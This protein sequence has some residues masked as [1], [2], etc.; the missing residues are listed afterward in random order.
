MSFAALAAISLIGGCNRPVSDPA[1]L[2]AI[3]A[4]AQVLMRKHPV[5]SGSVYRVPQRDWPPVL[6]GLHPEMITVYGWGVDIR[7]KAYF[8]GGW[9]YDVPRNKRDL[10]M[11]E[12]CY[13]EPSRGVFWHGPC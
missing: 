13:S 8:D 11:S 4:E 2:N 9:G 6:R 3:R 1:K 12:R 5:A 10:P 7:T